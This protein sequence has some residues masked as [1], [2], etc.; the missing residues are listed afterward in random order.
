MGIHNCMVH[1]PHF[2]DPW[3]V[4]YE[5]YDYV[6]QFWFAQCLILIWNLTS[7]ELHLALFKHKDFVFLQIN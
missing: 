6:R 5:I 4:G 7:Q 1:Q 3:L 2:I